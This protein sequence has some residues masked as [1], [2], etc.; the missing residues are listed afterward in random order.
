MHAPTSPHMLCS[1]HGLDSFPDARRIET[2]SDGLQVLELRDEAVTWRH[3]FGPACTLLFKPAGFRPRAL[4]IDMDSTLI[5]EE[6]L[7]ELARARG[8]YAQVARITEEAMA[9]RMSFPE[10]F[11]Q[12]MALLAGISSSEIKTVG[13]RVQFHTGVEALLGACYRQGIVVHLVT[14]A[15]APLAELVAK[16]VGIDAVCATPMQVRGECLSGELAG[17]LVD[18]ARKAAYVREQCQAQRWAASELIAIGDGANDRLMMGEV[19]VSIGFGAKAALYPV[20]NSLNNSGDH[21][22]AIWL[23]AH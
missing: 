9:G 15:I 2:R 17:P 16:R 7:D 21:S 6:S 19:A 14:G 8:R 18:G 11:Q 20:I 3:L 23:L 1:P 12:R 22:L 13:E 10:A 4:F 5:R